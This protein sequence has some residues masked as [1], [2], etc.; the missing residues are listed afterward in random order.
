MK[1]SLYKN[2]IKVTQ[3]LNNPFQICANPFP[4]LRPFYNFC[5]SK[6]FLIEMKRRLYLGEK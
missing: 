4:A 1:A 6:S 5:I 3:H 2:F